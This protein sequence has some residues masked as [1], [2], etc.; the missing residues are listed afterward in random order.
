MAGNFLATAARR[1]NA[2]ATRTYDAAQ[3]S[4]L[5]SDWLQAWIQSALQDVRYDNR[6][7][8]A[9]ARDLERN[10]PHVKRFLRLVEK[11]VIGPNG[12]LLQPR[13]RMLRGEKLHEAAND[14]LAA[15]WTDW[16][17]KDHCTVTGSMSWNSASRLILRTMVRDGEAFVRKWRYA[18][19]SH[20]FAIQILDADL[21]DEYYEVRALPNGNC[22]RMGIEFDRFGRAAAYHVWN[23]HPQD[24]GWGNQPL[25]R[26][27][28]PASEIEHLFI[29]Q[30]AGQPRGVTWLHAVMKT[31]KI[32][33]GY[34]EAELVAART[35][36]AKM[37][38]IIT[39][40][41]D[42]GPDPTA[43]DDASDR[44][45]DA[46]PGAIEELEPGQDFRQWDPQHPS[47][48]FR[49][50]KGAILRETSMGLDVAAASLT[51]DLSDVN[52]SSIRTGVID[53][54]DTWKEVQY[55]IIEHLHDPV[56]RAWLPCAQLTGACPLSGPAE[57]WYDVAWRPRGWAWTDPLKDTQAAVI[58]VGNGFNSPIRV[59][60][61]NG[62]DFFEII[63]EIALAQNTAKALGVTFAGLGKPT[64]LQADGTTAPTDTPPA[65][66]TSAEPARKVPPANH[67]P[68]RLARSH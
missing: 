65:D 35:A 11:N 54:R 59:C 26:E 28:I 42:A 40:G 61:E 62:D 66:T 16:T 18:D 47:G 27:R 25:A 19:N 41:D 10:N 3:F 34:S 14:T 58:D 57:R 48:N 36:A 56:F 7:L 49:A 1:V 50:F 37:G 6:T 24:T 68:L 32:D 39:T 17:R 20:G 22:I 64:A 29:P 31:L 30:R 52:Y 45:M 51:G 4:R 21:V 33:G 46:S 15:S 60:A 9:R 5:T 43:D 2:R 55:W 63:E 53:E 38:F 67:A 8:R 13:N 44:V 12:I 23:Q